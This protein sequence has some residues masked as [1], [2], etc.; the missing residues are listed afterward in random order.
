MGLWAE[1]ND[2]QRMAH[3]IKTGSDW[4][5]RAGNE[6]LRD[7]ATAYLQND[8]T[9]AIQGDNGGYGLPAPPP[10]P[11]PGAGSNTAGMLGVVNHL[12]RGSGGTQTPEQLQQTRNEQTQ[13]I[14]PSEMSG[15]VL[16]P[17]EKYVIGCEPA[18]L[19]AEKPAGVSDYV[20][21][22]VQGNNYNGLNVANI[23]HGNGATR[24]ALVDAGYGDWVKGAYEQAMDQRAAHYGGNGSSNPWDTAQF[25]WY[26][27]RYG[28][29]RG[30][31]PTNRSA[32]LT[33]G[34]SS[35]TNNPQPRSA[36]TGYNT[37]PF[38]PGSPVP[39]NNSASAASP[40]GHGGGNPGYSG[41][42]S[43]PAESLAALKALTERLRNRG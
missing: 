26:S 18:Q 1:M 41:M 23:T 27:D 40:P 16:T 14:M 25:D 12:V 11:T 39:V 38:N 8:S 31:T 34:G 33:Y 17:E 20:W 15:P 43:N 19:P 24:D 2:V 3:S 35:D 13:A 4:Q 37:G 6:G 7:Q 22:R 29:Y 9:P 42:L 10:P 28:D 32:G 36:T 21:Q 30:A 5:N